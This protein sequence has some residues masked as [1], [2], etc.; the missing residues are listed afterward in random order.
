MALSRPMKPFVVSMVVAGLIGAGCAAQRPASDEITTTTT[1]ETTTSTAQPATTMPGP[2]DLFGGSAVW[3]DD[4]EPPTLNPFAPFGDSYIVTKIGQAIY[5]RGWD[6]DPVAERIVPDILM[7]IPTV[8]NGGVTVNDDGTMTVRYRIRDEVVWSDGVPLSGSDLAFTIDTQAS[9]VTPGAFG[10]VDPIWELITGYETGDKTI[11]VTLSRP[12]IQYEQLFHWILPRHVVEGTDVLA[13]WDRQPFLGAGPFVFDSW[14][15]GQRITLVRNPN[16]WK[17]D[18]QTGRSLPYLD[19]LTFEFIP[20]TEAL[21]QAFADRELDALEPPPGASQYSPGYFDD[22]AVDYQTAPGPLWEHISFEFGPNNRNEN[23]INRNLNYRHAVAYAIGDSLDDVIGYWLPIDSHLDAGISRLSTRAWDRYDYD[24]EQ[25]RD[26]LQQAMAE[27][28]V[29]TVTAIFSTTSNA[30]ERPRI[31]MALQAALEAVGIDYENQL[32]DSQLFFGDTTTRGTFDLGLWAWVT[33]P[34]HSG[35]VG[36][37]DILD[38]DGDPERGLNYYRWGTP[39]SSVQDEST[40]RFA[41]ILA[42]ARSTVDGDEIERLVVEAEQLL[43][44]QA[45]LLP[46]WARTIDL[47]VWSDRLSGPVT[48]PSSSS[49]LWNVEEWHRVDR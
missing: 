44:D 6:F 15:P 26:L 46:L 34:T 9:I 5:A 2:P 16:Y 39:D 7:E 38:P 13:D 23:S 10:P 8:G 17:T 24:P 30:D 47:A 18:P 27:E 45:V 36:I 21:L 1:V 19:G 42:A 49:P 31:A 35:L 14:E 29:T 11:A 48:N 28:G 25:A 37:L 12:T 3:G 32:E 40:E 43:A 4:Q 41:E 22:P 33:D 20:E